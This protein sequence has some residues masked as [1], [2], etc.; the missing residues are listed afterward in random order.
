LV[1]PSSC[2]LGEDLGLVLLSVTENE[3]KPLKYPTL[4]N[5]ADVAII[6]KMDL[7]AAVEFDEQAKCRNVQAVRP[8]MQVLKLSSKTGD[9]IQAFLDFLGER[10]GRSPRL[11]KQR[12][13]PPS[14]L[15]TILLHRLSCLPLAL[16]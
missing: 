8:G 7:A 3:D 9:G 4:F 15:A 11:P 12:P 16:L 1:C 2:D 10:R 5:S 6:T 13:G 14:N